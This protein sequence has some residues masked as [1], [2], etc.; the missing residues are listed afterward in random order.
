M[1]G[2]VRGETLKEDFNDGKAK[3]NSESNNWISQAFT[4]DSS[5]GDG[6]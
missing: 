1:R 6:P 2:T 3:I 4:T 5:T